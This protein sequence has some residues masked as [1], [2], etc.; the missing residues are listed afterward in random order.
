MALDGEYS[1]IRRDQP[2]DSET[3]DVLAYAFDASPESVVE[4]LG[5]CEGADDGRSGWTW[6]RLQ[7]GDLMLGLF[8]RGE[9][10][11]AVEADAQLPQREEQ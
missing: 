5:A 6:L 7:N 11:F 2:P 4:V 10:Y 8:P 1:V 9:T 3:A